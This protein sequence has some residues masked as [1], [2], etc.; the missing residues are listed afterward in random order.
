MAAAMIGR[1]TITA[2][3]SCHCITTMATNAETALMGPSMLSRMIVTA[4]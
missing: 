1:N 2:R 4:V 3:A